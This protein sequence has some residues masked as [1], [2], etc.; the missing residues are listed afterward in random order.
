ME[1]AMNVLPMEKQIQVVNALVEGNSVRATARMVDVEHKTV[2]RVLL[3]AGD[4]CR[5]LLDERM[6]GLHCRFIQPMKSGP[7]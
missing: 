7:T 4:H 1:D 5:S 6:R 2:L 3:R